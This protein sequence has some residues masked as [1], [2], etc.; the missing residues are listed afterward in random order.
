MKTKRNSTQYFF[1]SFSLGD[2][3]PPLAFKIII[4]NLNDCLVFISAAPSLYFVLISHR[5]ENSEQF[6][7][8]SPFIEMHYF[9]IH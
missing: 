9:Q 3:I 7:K 1:F 5:R 2:E 4:T 8:Y 6:N